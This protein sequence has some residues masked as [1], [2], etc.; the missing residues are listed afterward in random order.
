MKYVVKFTNQFKKDYK[1]AQKQHKNISILKSVVNMLANGETLPEKYCDHILIG[2]YK[3]K[4]ECH[5]E[6]DWLLIYEYDGD[7]LILWLSRTGTHSDLF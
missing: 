1:K 4:H 5:L 7:E 2:N 6:P 3:G